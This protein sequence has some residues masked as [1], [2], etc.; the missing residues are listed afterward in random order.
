MKDDENVN[1]LEHRIAA[2]KTG[3][4]RQPLLRREKS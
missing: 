4:I 3:I 1:C 2:M